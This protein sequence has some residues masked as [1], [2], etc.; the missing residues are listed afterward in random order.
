MIVIIIIIIIITKSIKQKVLCWVQK[1]KQIGTKARL[2]SE[3]LVSYVARSKSSK[4]KN[5]RQLN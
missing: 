5:V 4:F 1:Q 3:R 2:D